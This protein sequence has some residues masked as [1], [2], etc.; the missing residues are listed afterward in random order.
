MQHLAELGRLLAAEEKAGADNSAAPEGLSA[1]LRQWQPQAVRLGLPAELLSQVGELLGNY[2]HLIVMARQARLGRILPLLR[3]AYVELRDGP[4]AGA[5]AA[6]RQDSATPT[7][8]IH[9]APAPTKPR[10]SSRTPPPPKGATLDSPLEKAGGL[11]SNYLRAFKKMGLSTIRDLLYHFPR[12]YDDYS[13]LRKIQ[14]LMYGS[15][16]TI[17]GTIENVSQRRTNRGQVLITATVRDETGTIDAVWFNQPFLLKS[18]RPGM[19]VVFSG[20]VDS[21]RGRLNLQSPEWERYDDDLTHTGR[22]V[23]VYPMSSGMRARGT[24]WILKRVVEQW[25]GRIPDPL[26]PAV[27]KRTGMGELGWALLQIHF[28]DDKESLAQARR[29]LAFDEFMLIQIGVLQRKREWQA[30]PGHPLAIDEDLLQ[31]FLQGLPFELTGAQQSALQQLLDDVQKDVPMSRLLQGDVGSG[32][33]VVA[34]A[35]MLMAVANGRQAALMA[36]TEILAEQHARTIQQLLGGMPLPGRPSAAHIETEGD[37]WKEED[38]E[39]AERVAALKSM[40][41]IEAEETEGAPKVALLVGSLK[42]RDKQALREQ[43]AAGKVDIVIGTHALI[44]E[45]VA[46]ADLGLA[47]IDEQ[48]RFG[49]MQRRALHQKG[50]NPHLLVM[51]ATPIPR[52][53]ALTLHGDLDLCLIDEMPPGRQP[54]R[55][56]WLAN[57]ERQRAYDFIREQV[58]EGRQAFVICPLVEESDKIEAAAAVEEYN[59]LQDEVFADLKLGLLHGRMSGPEKERIMRA[60][61]DGETDILVST[62]VVEVG[63]DVPNATV[64][65]VEG[66]ERFGLAQ[67]HQ[68][69]GRVGRGEQPSYCI[70]LA[71]S[72]DMASERLQAIEETIDGFAL[73]E[74]DLELRGPGEFFGTRQSGMPDLKIA[75]LGDVRLLELAR[76]E[77]ETILEQD[78]FL[79]QPEHAELAER[80]AEFWSQAVEVS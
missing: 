61:R 70:L 18:L 71:T 42:K 58:E 39:R 28:P 69:R 33:T 48:H 38:P 78:P 31:R 9:P 51:T 19:R 44:Q 2:D 15:T 75:R 26:P 4:A 27:R 3:R 1:Y 77:A 13:S 55:T 68:F 40:L 34:A 65:M 43:I 29:R 45:D 11:R 10:E 8:A 17:I 80:V 23:P 54:I 20:K 79:D 32:K 62:A 37:E 5:P 22:L 50:Y 74:I 30:E 46:F 35:A 24:R 73:A 59:R 53:L 66:A 49:V 12:R 7:I 6:R 14:D 64:M 52:T 63:I 56:R 72:D 21:F 57:A 47:V 67:L 41:G 25:A 36:P 16:E 76:Q 60:F